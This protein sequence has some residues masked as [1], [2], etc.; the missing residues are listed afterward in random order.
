MQDRR[1][2]DHIHPQV[3]DWFDP[4]MYADEELDFLLEHLG[5]SNATALR[6]VGKLKDPV[7]G[8]LQ[9]A[10]GL[11]LDTV[12]HALARFREVAEMHEMDMV[13]WCG[14]DAI[15]ERIGKWRERQRRAAT[16]K[17]QAG[18]GFVPEMHHYDSRQRPHWAGPGSDSA[19]V[20]RF[21][22]RLIVE[23]YRDGMG[24]VP[25]AGT[26][27]TAG[28]VDEAPSVETPK[29]PSTDPTDWELVEGDDF[30]QCPIDNHRED[31]NP[32]SRGSYNLARARM[33]RYMKSGKRKDPAFHEA[34]LHIFG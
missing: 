23:D 6:E 27:F 30:I 7:T 33:A 21:A 1:E 15:R 2:I 32:D 31:F 24:E 22:L 14:Y 5:E 3:G 25:V 34:A 9:T 16:N 4:A 26:D 18:H 17:S 20:R 28:L 8:K 29:A 12:S 19:R 13:K 10:P 11:N